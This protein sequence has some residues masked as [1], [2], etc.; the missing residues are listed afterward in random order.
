[1]KTN[2]VEIVQRDQCT[3]CMMCGDICPQN[4]IQFH[5]QY[6]GFWYPTVDEEK[7]ISC[8]L[9]MKKCPQMVNNNLKEAI[10]VEYYGVKSKSEKTRWESTSGG[11]FTELA[12]EWMSESGICC[13][14]IYDSNNQVYHSIESDING[15]ENL[16][17]SKYVQSNTEGIFKEVK[18]FLDTENKVLFCGTPCQVEALLKFLNKDYDN[19]LTLDFVCCGICSPGVY[20][21]YLKMLEEEYKSKIKRIWF[22]NKADGWRSIGTRIE[23]ENR[24]VYFRTG[25]RDLYMTAFVN[26]ALSMRESCQ[27][28]KY[29]KIPHN[30]D[31]TVADF[32]GIEKI[33]PQFDDNKGVSAVFVNTQKGKK[34]FKKTIPSLDYF[35]T[36][37]DDIA[38][39]NFTIYRPKQINPNRKAFFELMYQTSFKNAMRVYGSYKGIKKIK[40]NISFAKHLIR[41]KIN[42]LLRRK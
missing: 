29:R 22:K 41:V 26:D 33:D 7:C 1:M 35:E 14:A 40:V 36:T 17:Q 24:K 23:F 21:Q 20:N 9:C 10:E 15:I 30:S 27:N 4:A 25:N 11:F 13:G 2:T 37:I 28:C 31:L 12:L 32:W 8:G 6:D 18:R 3:G 34:W 5:D 16:R 19:L 38:K 42:E 39:G